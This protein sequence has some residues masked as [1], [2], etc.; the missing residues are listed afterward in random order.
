[1]FCGLLEVAVL[2]EI[3]QRFCR[4]A[5][6]LDDAMFTFSRVVIEPDDAWR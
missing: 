1:M 4:D 5:H 2:R 6:H 3:G